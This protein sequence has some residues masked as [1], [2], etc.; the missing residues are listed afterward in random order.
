MR[1]TAFGSLL[2]LILCM[3]TAHGQTDGPSNSTAST[4]FQVLYNFTDHAD[5]CC[6]LAGVARDH[7]GNLYGVAYLSDNEANFGD[8]FKLTRGAKTY[9]FQVLKSF[10]SGNGGC[11]GTPTVDA[12]GNV[13]GVCSGTGSGAGTLWEVLE[14]GSFFS[15]A[16]LQRTGRRHVSPGLGCAR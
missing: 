9:T 1:R 10:N 7:A 12:S 13:F 15:V 5:G 16:H 8:L 2:M 6:I 11:M 14:Q 3:Y 4:G